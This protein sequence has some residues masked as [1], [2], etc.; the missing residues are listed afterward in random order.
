MGTPEKIDDLERK[1][2]DAMKGDPERIERQHNAG[3]MTA[4]ERITMLLDSDSFVELDA[5]VKH[6]SSNF[7]LEKKRP[8]GDGVITGHGTID[9]RTVYIFAQDFAVFGGQK[10]DVQ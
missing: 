7:G 4:R 2:E 10:P 6:R 3:K 5:L 8:D 9:G 1:L